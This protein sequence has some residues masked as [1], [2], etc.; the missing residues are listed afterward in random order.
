[1]LEKITDPETLRFLFLTTHY[2]QPLEYSEDKI[3]EASAALNRIYTFF[4]ELEHT[5]GSKN[6][7]DLK[8][9]VL[10]MY[11]TFNNE[12]GNALNDDFNTP[13]AVAV[14]FE[15]VR[16]ANTIIASKPSLD[17]VSQL[18]LYGDKIKERVKKVLGVL[19]Y[20][21]SE[22]FKTRLTIPE[23]E[24]LKLIERRSQARANKDF[25]TADAVRAELAEKGVELLDT[26]TGTRYRTK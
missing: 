14:L 24:V 26:P 3:K 7:K 10:E 12:F 25:A 2:R 18:K 16:L 17:T 11:N 20:S 22:W 21:P 8:D 5:V 4:D 1:M 6:G 13:R 19:N 23:D 9:T 15:A